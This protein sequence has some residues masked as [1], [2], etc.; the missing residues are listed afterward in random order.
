VMERREQ[1][2]QFTFIAYPLSPLVLI[3]CMR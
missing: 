3:P 2:V 1:P